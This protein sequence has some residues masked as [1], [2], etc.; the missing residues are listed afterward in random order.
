MKIV[1]LLA[2]IS[3]LAAAPPVFGKDKKDK[4][5]PSLVMLWPDSADARIKLTFGKFV[6][7]AS[8]KGQLSLESQVLIENVSGKRIPLA[9]FTVYLLDKDKI[10][11]GNGNLSFADLDAGQQAKL[12]FQ[13]FS[14]GIPSTLSLAA[15]NDPS[16]IPTS[17]R[18]VP[19]NV[20]STPPGAAIKVDGR[21]A[22]ITP[23]TIR[24]SVG[25]HVLAF[26]KEGYSSGSTPVDIKPDEGLGGSISFELGG[27][28]RDNVE[29]RN[30]IVLEGDVISMSMTDVVVRVDGKDQIVPRNQ[31]SKMIL[32]ERIVTEQPPVTQTIPAKP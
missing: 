21:D 32:V 24:L 18:T 17:L 11:I 22:G 20:I 12:A 29:L 10:R 9:S 4:P 19:L 3:L 1:F 13:V 23:T 16:G 25:N 7:L 2:A 8:Y 27:L 15:R 28:S 30:G 26:S 31:V 14:L 6:Q 5:E